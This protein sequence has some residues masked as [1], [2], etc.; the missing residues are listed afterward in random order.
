MKHSPWRAPVRLGCALLVLLALPPLPRADTLSLVPRVAPSKPP[1]T[2]LAP[3]LDPQ[4]VVVKF[5]EGTGVRLKRTP[6]PSLAMP[7][8][9]GETLNAILKSHSIGIES[10]QRLFTRS[11][12]D[13]DA[14]REEAQRRSGREQAD[15]NLYYQVELPDGA[16]AAR[17]WMN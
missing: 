10:F 14:E 5:G 13:L 17:F 12:E 8:L 15:L 3:T 7:P 16:D 4:V 1:K 6:S 9:H 11:E 2:V